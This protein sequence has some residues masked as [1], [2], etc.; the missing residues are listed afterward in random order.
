MQGFESWWYLYFCNYYHT[1]PQQ[2][3]GIKCVELK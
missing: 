3:F 1:K 2:T